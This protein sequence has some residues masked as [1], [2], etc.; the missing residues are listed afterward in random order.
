MKKKGFSLIELLVSLAITGIVFLAIFHLSVL[1]GKQ[2][3][4]YIERYNAYN[5]LSFALADMAARCPSASSILDGFDSA[6]TSKGSFSFIGSSNIY[7]I[8]PYEGDTEYTYE[9]DSRDLALEI[10]N[11]TTGIRSRQV[12][13][14]AKFNP[15]IAFTRP[16]ID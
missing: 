3:Q 7:N 2:I 14:E 6:E 4:I 10:T 8:T 15:E 5:Q 16:V 11:K 9:V 1:T 12:L 13:V